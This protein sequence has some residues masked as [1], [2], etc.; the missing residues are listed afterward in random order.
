MAIKE[1]AKGTKKTTERSPVSNGAQRIIGE[2]EPY[3]AR[4][5][6][7]GVAPL[8]FHNY[9]VESVAE[10]GKAAKGSAAKKSDDIESYVYRVSQEDD[11][12]GVPGANLCR[13]LA[14]AAKSI[15]DPRSPRKSMMDLVTA[16]V[17]PLDDVAPFI[18]DVTEWDFVDTRRVVIQRNAVPRQ[19]P[20]M[21]KGWTIMFTVGVQAPEYVPVETLQM[22]A[23]RA[24]MFQGLGDFRPTFGRFSVVN[25]ET[26]LVN[27]DD[28]R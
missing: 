27:A 26:G 6:V 16:S 19:R 1:P 28:M 20:A 8:L 18:P 14:V 3:V 25:F 12:L 24:G 23:T 22:L 4:I 15:P 5:T 9:N 7:K 13:A 2:H 17:I 11:R 10:K 21:H